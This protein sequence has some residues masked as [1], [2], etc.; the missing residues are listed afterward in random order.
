MSIYIDGYGEVSDTV[1]VG[2]ILSA[3]FSEEDAEN[4]DEE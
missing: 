1:D 3:I 4:D 2:K